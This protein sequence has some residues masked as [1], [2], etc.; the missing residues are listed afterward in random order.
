MQ[1]DCKDVAGNPELVAEAVQT[2]M[3]VFKEENPYEKLKALTR[4]RKSTEEEISNLIDVL[5]KVPHDVKKRMKQLTA[6]NYTGLAEELVD[7]YFAES[8]H[9]PDAGA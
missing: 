7:L 9:R 5:E 3:R 6:E 1:A 4:G 2:I 8:G